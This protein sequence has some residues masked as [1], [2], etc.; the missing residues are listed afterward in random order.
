M[1]GVGVKNA[2]LLATFS[3]G[4]DFPA[5]RKIGWD[6]KPEA[7]SLTPEGYSPWG[8]AGFPRWDG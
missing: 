5:I 4:A 8:V 2:M 7:G 3:G 6:R 1:A